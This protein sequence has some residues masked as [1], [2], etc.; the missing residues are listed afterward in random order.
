MKKSIIKFSTCFILFSFF[1]RSSFAQLA[2]LVDSIPMGDG[3]KL[4]ADIYIPAGITQGPVIL[5]QTPY[6]RLFYHFTGL[7]LQIGMN[8]NTSN[9]IFVILDWRGFYGSAAAGYLGS[10]SL[11]QDGYDCVEWIAQQT[12]SNGL[13]GTWGPS[14]LGRVQFQTARENPPHLTCICPLV[15]GPQYDYTEYYPHGDL[16]TE[17]VQQL[18]VLGFGLSPILLAHPVHDLTWAFAENANFYPDSI[19][20]PC[21]M[22]GGWYDH[23]VESMIP[24]FNAIRTQSPVN[25]QD[26][27]RL[28]MGPW[29]HGGSGI[30]Q[31]GSAVQ[32]E[33]IYNNAAN[34]NDSLALMFFDYHL[35]SIAN[36]WG[37]TPFVQYYQMGNDAWQNSPV[38]PPVS[39]VP[40]N[41]YLHQNGALDNA[42][43]ASSTGSLT[44]NYNPNDPSPTT[45][46]PTLR[47]DLEQGPYDQADSVESRNDILIFTTGSLTQN[48]VM[49]GNA[50]IHLKVSSDKTDTDFDIRLTDV[51]PDGRSMLVN[52]GVMRMRFRNG[53]TANDTAAMIPGTVY[54]CTIAL[55]NTA[56][57]FLAGHKI[58]VDI[59]SSNYPRFNRNMNTGG[60]M[61]PANNL[62]TLVNPVIAA[63]TV[64]TSSVNTSYITLPLVGFASGINSESDL[65]DKINLF[66]NPAN[67]IL[68]VEAPG[69]SFNLVIS[70]LPGRKIFSRKNL[71]EKEEID[72][73]NFPGGV[74]F[75]CITGSKQESYNRKII[76]VH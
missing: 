69:N 20:V 56:I 71:F 53:N 30:A 44:L 55:P 40:V 23:T 14:A 2:P 4:A 31:V 28:L 35:R 52:D 3:K 39:A 37:A 29:V 5:I 9:Y 16:R 76:I 65:D 47:T 7:P 64:Y 73:E 46:G 70:D 1:V 25:V 63:N 10:P 42:I 32:G 19:K 49:K 8:V 59:T 13:I 18:D 27:H 17:Y 48:A 22:I 61:Y 62:D 26:D 24:F 67:N 58:R 43:P 74:Y 15:A 72:C 60:S 6:N 66:P 50:A 75:I 34:W 68:T 33:L 57:T 41:F 54:D 45:G 38:W 21:F 12:W 36:G 11:G 51:Y